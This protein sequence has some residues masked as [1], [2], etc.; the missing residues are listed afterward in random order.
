MG[1]VL[2]KNNKG[3]VGKTWI[4]LQLAAYKAMCKNKKILILTSDSQN[5]ILNFAGVKTDTTK[6]GLED[7]LQGKNYTVTKLRPNLFFL[8]LQGYKIKKDFENKFKEAIKEFKKEYDEII[9]DG[10]PVLELDNVFID[11]AEHIV[12]PTFLDA[13]TTN[14]ILSMFRKININKI[15][16][17]IPNRVGRTKIE[18]DYYQFLDDKL[19]KTGIFLSFPISQS[20]IIS[21]LIDKGTIL[22][23][24]KIKRL[25]YVKDI[26]ISIWGEIENE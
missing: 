1:V 18:S 13:I 19:K 26:F 21:K 8:H 10:S 22:W 3:G 16:A 4:T 2:I 25:E 20:S 15:R 6:K 12:I 14:S 5:N 17:I 23:E 7:Y 11:V 9:I 24:S